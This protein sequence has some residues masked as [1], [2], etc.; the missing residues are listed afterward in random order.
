MI[1]KIGRNFIKYV[2]FFAFSYPIRYE[3]KIFYK[4]IDIFRELSVLIHKK[5]FKKES[6]FTLLV[7]F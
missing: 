6:H 5:V 4:V 1:T 7:T 3:G 2:V